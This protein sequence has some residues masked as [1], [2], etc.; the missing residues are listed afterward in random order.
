MFKVNN[1]DMRT[2][3]GVVIM[4]LLLTVNIFRNLL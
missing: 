2:T 4:S 3:P 1:K